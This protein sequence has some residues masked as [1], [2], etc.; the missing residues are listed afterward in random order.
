MGRF[1]Y[2]YLCHCRQLFFT[3]YLLVLFVEAIVDLP[4]EVPPIGKQTS[5]EE[6]GQL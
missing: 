5:A 6:D 1:L 2:D 3:P 4:D